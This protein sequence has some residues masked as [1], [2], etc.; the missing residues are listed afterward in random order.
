MGGVSRFSVENCSSHSA[1]NLWRGILFVSILS[2]IEKVYAAEGYGTIFPD[3][4]CL[5]VSNKIL[6]EP[7][8]AV[9]QKISGS[10]NFYV[11]EGARDYQ[12]FPS[13]FLS[14]SAERFCRGTL[15]R[16]VPAKFRL[17]ISLC[18]IGVAKVSRLSVDIFLSHSTVKCRTGI[19]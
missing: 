5:T 1:E 19:L 11:K 14:H 15:V 10:E 7:Y 17:R 8:P 2:G 16:Y 9:F 13:N 4:F 6:G 18:K 12:V 3:F